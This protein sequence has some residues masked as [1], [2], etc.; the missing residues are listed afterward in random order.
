M[1]STDSTTGWILAFWVSFA[2]AI[3]RAAGAKHEAFQALAHLWCG[4]LLLDWWKY[5]SRPAK[6]FVIA[7]SVVEVSM[8]LYQKFV[9]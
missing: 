4:G 8:F 6:W 3:F 9:V 2:I 7:L 5:G 1:S